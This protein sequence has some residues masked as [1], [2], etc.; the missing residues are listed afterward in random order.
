MPS[1]PQ[2][3]FRTG[4]PAPN[5]LGITVSPGNDEVPVSP[6]PTHRVH[7]FRDGGQVHVVVYTDAGRPILCGVSPVSW[8]FHNGGGQWAET[9]IALGSASLCEHGGSRDEPARWATSTTR[10]P[11]AASAA[12]RQQRHLAGFRDIDGY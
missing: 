2:V 11:W 8:P 12:R 10:A 9:V 6:P 4:A 7:Y 3:S 1:G 5:T